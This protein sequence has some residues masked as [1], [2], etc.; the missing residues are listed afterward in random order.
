MGAGGGR[1]VARRAGARVE[2]EGLGGKVEEHRCQVVEASTSR[3][4]EGRTRSRPVY[5]IG[6]HAVKILKMCVTSS[7]VATAPRNARGRR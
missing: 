6:P 5:R 7:S 2:L 3:F 4:H 1:E